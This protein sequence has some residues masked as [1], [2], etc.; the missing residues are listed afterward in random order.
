SISTLPTMAFFSL[1]R[2]YSRTRR[3]SLSM[4]GNFSPVANQRDDQSRVTGRRKP[5]GLIFCPMVF[6]E[7]R[8]VADCHVDVTGLLFDL[9][10]TALRTGPEAPQRPGLL[11]VD[12]LDLELVDVRTVVVLGVGDGRLDHLL[13]D[14]G[15]FLGRE[16]QDVQGPLDGQP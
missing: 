7:L 15:R 2:R 13:D 10:A 5:I 16:A 4:A 3:S 9:G 8:S 12:P 14:G 11:D 6:L 1:R